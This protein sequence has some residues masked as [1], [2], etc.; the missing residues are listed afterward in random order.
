ML[1]SN[2]NLEQVGKLSS[3]AEGGHMKHLTK[4]SL[5]SAIWLAFSVLLEQSYKQDYKLEIMRIQEDHQRLMKD[6]QATWDQALLKERQ[7]V[8]E[9]REQL[10]SM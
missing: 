10:R 2:Q 4:A 6:K 5:V 9:F 8:A 3:Q 1:V 7:A